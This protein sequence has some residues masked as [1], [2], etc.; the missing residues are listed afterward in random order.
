MRPIER[1]FSIRTVMLILVCGGVIVTA[2]V[3][4]W[5]S[6]REYRDRIG[7]SLIAASQA[8]MVAVDN[9]LDEPLAFVSGLSNSSSFA[10]G[11]F[12]NFQDRARD[13]LSPRGYIVIIKSADDDQEYLNTSK[14]PA[15]EPAE[16]AAS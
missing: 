7:S 6:Y 1:T 13:A 5:L 15:S 12:N 8:V 14:P 2:L 4:G 16:V 11:D 3:A 10:K 9:E